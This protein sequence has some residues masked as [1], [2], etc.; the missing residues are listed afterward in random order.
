[1]IGIALRK[2][3]SKPHFIHRTFAEYFV[4]DFLINHLTKK[5]KL[6]VQVKELLRN[7]VLLQKDCLVI[8]AFLNSLLEN[9]KPS[10]EALKDYGDLLD[11]QWNLGEG[12]GPLLV[13]TTA[14]HEAAAENIPRIIGFILDSLKSGKHSNA[15]KVILLAKDY[16]RRT[17][18]HVAAEAGHIE[19]VECLWIWAKELLKTHELKN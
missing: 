5:T 2:N 13:D 16:N 4:A 12:Q 3:E 15:L 18:W 7:K 14:L 1:M 6:H 17:A 9:S 19:V 10:T 11:E 8:R